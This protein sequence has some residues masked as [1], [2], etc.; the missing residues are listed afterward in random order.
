MPAQISLLSGLT[1]GQFYSL[2]TA[3]FSGYNNYDVT[4]KRKK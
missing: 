2:D 3:D 4:A 1:V